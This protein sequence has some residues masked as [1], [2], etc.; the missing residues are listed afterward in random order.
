M[1]GQGRCCRGAGMVSAVHAVMVTWEWSDAGWRHGADVGKARRPRR[2]RKDAACACQEH[3]EELSGSLWRR[4]SSEL[5]TWS[6]YL[7]ISF[8]GKDCIC[9]E[10]W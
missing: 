3:D 7:G 5:G 2:S 9:V 1:G 6:C 10:G 4:Q 8:W